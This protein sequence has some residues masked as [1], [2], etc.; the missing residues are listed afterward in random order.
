MTQSRKLTVFLVFAV[1]A[2]ACGSTTTLPEGADI[3]EPEIV[4]TTVPETTA[5][6]AETAT[7]PSTD[8]AAAATTA[9]AEEPAVETVPEP[10]EVFAVP[11]GPTFQ[12]LTSVEGV[13]ELLPSLVGSTDDLAGLGARL[14]PFPGVPT[15]AET[16]VRNASVQVLNQLDRN[17][18]VE[19]LIVDVTIEG[20]T[21]ALSEDAHLAF[22]A[23]LGPAGISLIDTS[24]TLTRG[25][26]A[27]GEISLATRASGSMTF[28]TI[29]YR[30]VT[31]VV[32]TEF[33]DA[34][35]VWAGQGPWGDGVLEGLEARVTSSL[36]EYEAIVRHRFAG[37]G[38][39][40]LRLSEA[41]RLQDSPWVATGSILSSTIVTLPGVEGETQL[42][43][44]EGRDGGVPETL[45]LF[46]YGDGF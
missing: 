41:L 39:D 40:D 31:E 17:F 4:E 19:G 12:E 18:E 22:A 28:F 26:S 25:E 35:V 3:I 2:A 33:V 7:V 10:V 38:A 29:E 16:E 37:I 20:L 30:R 46:S 14:A 43:L 32:D 34:S 13:R 27:S 6:P 11:A 1:V 9:V 8:A 24:A 42:N 36:N 15:F 21:P 44:V 5:A 23:S 45:Q